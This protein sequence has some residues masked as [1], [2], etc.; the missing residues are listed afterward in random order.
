MKIVLIGATGYVGSAILEEALNRGHEVTAIVRHPEKIT[1][2]KNLIAK[3]GDVFNDKELAQLI[4]GHEAVIS[5]FNPFSSKETISDSYQ[6][7]ITGTQLLINAVKKAGVKRVL[8][9]GGAGSLEV[10]PGIQLVNTPEFP[11]EWKDMALAMSE[12]LTILKKE[13]QLPWTLLSPSAL[14]KP[15]ERSGKFRLG[16][17]Q[18]ITDINGESKISTQD[19]AVAMIDE[20]EIPKHTYKRFTVGY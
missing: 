1:P 14:L 16:G 20:L 11:K 10:A 18:L 5:A 13:H 3:K 6:K 12:V 4:E 19:Y 17:D 8:M 15:G 7:Q 2:C 9:V